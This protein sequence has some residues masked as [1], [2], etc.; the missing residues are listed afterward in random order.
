MA[1]PILNGTPSRSKSSVSSN[2]ETPSSSATLPRLICLR[3][4]GRA[5]LLVAAKRA[6]L[7]GE[8]RPLLDS[9]VKK[10]YFLS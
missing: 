10:G 5:G 3:V 8:V 2:R 4:K 9:M 6:G 7:V 1:G